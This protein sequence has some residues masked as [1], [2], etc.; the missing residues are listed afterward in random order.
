MDFF[1][2]DRVIDE[3]PHTIGAPCATTWFKISGIKNPTVEEY[4]NKV[5][6]FMNL[7]DRAFLVEFSNN[8]YSSEE[9]GSHVREILRRQIESVISG[10]NKEVEKR[11]RYYVSHG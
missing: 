3:L 5:V 6:S 2:I 9:L 1:E 10:T 4:R 8:A 11:Y 7:F